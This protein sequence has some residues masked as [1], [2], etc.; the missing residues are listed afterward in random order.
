MSHPRTDLPGML[1]H[2]QWVNI[3]A[4]VSAGVEVT[5]QAS[6]WAT[7]KS[8]TSLITVAPMWQSGYLNNV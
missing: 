2:P 4:G 3:R 6:I 5:W 7:L 1:S 8:T